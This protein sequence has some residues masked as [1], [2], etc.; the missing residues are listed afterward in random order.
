MS[1]LLTRTQADDAISEAQ[2]FM[3]SERG[4]GL[5]GGF[6]GGQVA[7]RVISVRE[8]AEALLRARP[9]MGY[10][11]FY[12]P[13]GEGNADQYD[14]AASVLPG[15][16]VLVPSTLVEKGASQFYPAVV[17]EDG[18]KDGRLRLHVLRQPYRQHLGYG[19]AVML[20]AA[21][22]AETRGVGEHRS[23]QA[24]GVEAEHFATLLAA[25]SDPDVQASWRAGRHV[26]H[27]WRQK[28]N[29]SVTTQVSRRLFAE[30]VPQSTVT[31][32]KSQVQAGKARLFWHEGMRDE[33]GVP[34]TATRDN[35]LVIVQGMGFVALKQSD[36]RAISTVKELIN[37]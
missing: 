3:Q 23:G 7:E 34:E 27:A 15:H 1:E 24:E 33:R 2:D 16:M 12:E 30:D 20:S 13:L 17:S 32:T 28:P 11:G 35:A 6:A 26:N 4:L 8:Q 22:Q 5:D 9:L 21:G 25:G 31:I 14:M 36:R 18:I 10:D 19:A 37:G 29:S